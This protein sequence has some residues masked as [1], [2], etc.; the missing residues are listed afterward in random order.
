MTEINKRLNIGISPPDLEAII[1]TLSEND[2]VEEIILFGSRALGDFRPASGIDISIIGKKLTLNDQAKLSAKLEQ[3]LIHNFINLLHYNSIENKELIKHIDTHGI[4][5]WSKNKN[6]NNPFNNYAREYDQWFDAER[7]SVIFLQELDCLKQVLEPLTDNWLEVGVGSGRFA[8]ALG[9]KSGI[10]PSPAMVELAIDRGINTVVAVGEDM[11]FE[12]AA[13]DGVLM[14][15]M[16][17]FLDDLSATLRECWRVLKHKGRLVIG[18]IPANSPWGDYNSRRGK[19]GHKFYSS[20]HFY[21]AESVRTLAENIGFIFKVEHGCTLPIPDDAINTDSSQS[22][23]NRKE[24]F[25]AF[26]FAK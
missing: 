20:A 16:I 21:S 1:N 11:P 22:P 5:L 2:R 14:V 9:I 4:T 10:D 6:K 26:L 24:S 8:A 13:F 23:I 15:C 12:T 18:F 25:V 17:C 3:L 7:G 19:E